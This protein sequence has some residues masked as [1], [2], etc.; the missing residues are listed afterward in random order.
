MFQ[1][2]APLAGCALMMVVCMALMG[3]SHRK[4]P[5]DSPP[6]AS[7]DE[8]QALRDEVARLRQLEEERRATPQEPA[9]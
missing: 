9:P 7:T 4:P 2:L 8:I 3:A 6:P 5:A 1:S